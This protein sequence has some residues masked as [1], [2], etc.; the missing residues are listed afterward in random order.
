MGEEIVL[1]FEKSKNWAATWGFNNSDD[2]MVFIQNS[3]KVEKYE[4][5]DND[6]VN[7]PVK[8]V[9]IVFKWDGFPKISLIL[10]NK[11]EVIVAIHASNSQ[12]FNDHKSKI[13]E[14]LK[15]SDNVFL[16][17][18]L[19]GFGDPPDK[20]HP[21]YKFAKVITNKDAQDIKNTFTE[22]LEFVKKKLNEAIGCKTLCRFLPLDIDMQAFKKLLNEE[23]KE[24]EN[25]EKKERKKE[26]VAYLKEMLSDIEDSFFIDKLND[27]K[28]DIEE[29]TDENYRKDVGG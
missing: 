29:I 14:R 26:A 24:W 4:A 6:T 19:Y 27:A 17:A 8:T 25:E 20:N 11:V 10:Q 2:N 15:L 12:E 13:K 22:F 5:N 21:V 28:K 7:V 3:G 9:A 23:K 18:I 16:N 1:I